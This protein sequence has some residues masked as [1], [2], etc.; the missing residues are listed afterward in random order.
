MVKLN[1][2]CKHRKLPGFDNLDK[3]YGWYFQDG[4]PQ[5][6][7][8]W[9]EGITI[10]HALMF[11]TPA[12]LEKFTKEMWRVLKTGGVVRI[13]EDDTENPLSDMYKTGNIESGPRCLTGPKMMRKV[14]EGAGFKV[15][16]VDPSTTHFKDKSLMQA[17]RGGP[18]KRFFIEGV[19]NPIE[20]ERK[21]ALIE[22]IKNQ[23]R[24]FEIPD[25][26]RDD[27][28]QF[29]V[30]MGYKVGAEIG[31]YKGEFSE[32]FAKAGLELYSIDPWRIYKDYSN[33]RGQARLDFQYEHTKRVLAPYPK[34]KIIRKTSMEAVEDFEDGSL[35]F[36]YIDGNHEFRY[37]AEDLAE[38]TKKVRKG[39]I[40]SGHDYF[41]NKTGTGAQIW[42]VAHV[43][44]AYVASFNISNWYLVGRKVPLEGEK[45][46]K[47][48]SWMF[49]K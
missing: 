44:K 8:G 24:P 20:P 1:L 7:D 32:K 17:Y 46:D 11:L 14:L 30:D 15:Y 19:K 37:I 36:V 42:H 49:L 43:L 39:G 18:P 25:C 12:E 48:R 3:I 31:V 34:C 10:S 45:R 47:W 28:P 40:V 29:F 23:G 5:Y 4:L 22:G 6:P 35:D 33:P 41:F 16:D 21:S 2:G 9:V 13:T 27:L 38:W 26:S